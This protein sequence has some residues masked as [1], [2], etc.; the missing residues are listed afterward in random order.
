MPL[1]VDATTA[2]PPEFVCKLCAAPWDPTSAVACPTCEDIFC[3]GCIEDNAAKGR[4]CGCGE[5]FATTTFGPAHRSVR[6]LADAKLAV[7][8]KNF[9]RGCGWTGP[10]SELAGHHGACPKAVR[11][12][13]VPAQPIPDEL[14]CGI[15]HELLAAPASLPCCERLLCQPCAADSIALRA[16]CPMC[17]AGLALSDLRK[18]PKQIETQ[19]DDVAV[20]CPHHDVGC[21][22]AGPLRHFP[23]HIAACRFELRSQ[24]AIAEA[25]VTVMNDVPQLHVAAPASTDG[26]ASASASPST[27]VT[28]ATLTTLLHLQAPT[29]VDLADRKMPLRLCAV[30]DVSG[31]MKGEKLRLTKESL[32]FMVNELS[33]NDSFSI[34]LFDSTIER[35]MGM[36]VMHAEAKAAALT[37]IATLTDQNCTNLC[38]GLLEGVACVAEAQAAS[39]VE[40][41]DALLLF[42]DGQANE[43]IV[44]PSQIVAELKAAS[45]RMKKAPVVYTFGFGTDHNAT[46]LQ[47]ISESTQGSYYYVRD[48]TI[49]RSCFA[50]CLG[51]LISTVMTEIAVTFTVRPDSGVTV[52][53]VMTQYPTTVNANGS[54]TIAIKD[55]YSGEVRDLPLAL[56]VDTQVAC[57]GRPLPV[58]SFEPIAWEVVY[59]SAIDQQQHTHRVATRIALDAAP[60]A[61]APDLYVDE[62]RNRFNLTV[63]LLEAKKAADSRDFA[64]AR[65]RI[66]ETVTS[67]NCTPSAQTT[68]VKMMMAECARM[69]EEMSA[70]RYD[71]G[72]S[73]A[74][75]SCADRHRQQRCNDGEDGNMYETAWKKEMK[76]KK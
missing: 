2:I 61:G 42:T 1:F 65:T 8:C 56:A 9:L 64:Q 48:S 45:A 46:L 68:T 16:F 69:T 72:G 20:T 62:Q 33:A 53:T 38:G 58:A 39:A 10:R 31:S 71:R 29:L 22:F 18:A 76:K 70:T 26:A 50:D 67:T 54:T 13:P 66:M 3:A 34:V 55:M 7:T 36:T 19:L 14:Q 75:T 60:F 23:G 40:C 27:P 35:L 74:M 15:C 5:A 63:A 24:A 43:G 37:L 44:E 12:V 6:N 30:I 17:N 32:V 47:R 57:G 21:A 73:Q 49:L 28:A 59:T 41:A 11:R 52:L 25:T 51:G 4:S